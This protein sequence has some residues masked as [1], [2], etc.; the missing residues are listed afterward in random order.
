M[1]TAERQQILEELKIIRTLARKLREKTEIPVVVSC[2]RQC[3][4]YSG[5]ALWSLGEAERFE[6]ESA[7]E[8][9]P[10]R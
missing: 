9:E 7:E 6:F 3:E 2:A 8:K 4:V 5:V 1:G 10:Q